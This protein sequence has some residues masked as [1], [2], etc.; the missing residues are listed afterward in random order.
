MPIFLYSS[1][2]THIRRQPVYKTLLLPA[3]PCNIFVLL[4]H[5]MA[6]TD[7]VQK[8]VHREMKGRIHSS[9]GY[10][11]NDF[12]KVY[13]SLIHNRLSYENLNTQSN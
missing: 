4:Q 7:G 5:Q 12:T 13:L 3:Q 11:F 8:A 2:P 1:P 10:S 9:A 6:G